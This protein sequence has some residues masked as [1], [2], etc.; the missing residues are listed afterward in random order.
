MDRKRMSA[1]AIMSTLIMAITVIFSS[2][3][4]ASLSK[5]DNKNFDAE[6]VLQLNPDNKL[7]FEEGGNW[8][9]P[10]ASNSPFI[11]TTNNGNN[12]TFRHSGGRSLTSTD[13]DFCI[14]RNNVGWIA[15]ESP[16]TG[17]TK[18]EIQCN[19]SLGIKF[20]FSYDEPLN[21]YSYSSE[22]VPL[23]VDYRTDEL[24]GSS[25]YT[26]IPDDMGYSYFRF[27]EIGSGNNWIKYINIYYS[28]ARPHVHEWEHIDEDPEYHE[29]NGVAEHE[30]C[31]ICGRMRDMD[32][33]F[34]TDADLLLEPVVYDLPCDNTAVALK[35]SVPV[36]STSILEFDFKIKDPNERFIVKLLQDWSNYI[37]YHGGIE[38]GTNTSG[39]LFAG[40]TVQQMVGGWTRLTIDM[41]QLNMAYRV[42]GT[43]TEIKSIYVDKNTG[44]TTGAYLEVNSKA[45]NFGRGHYYEGLVDY[46]YELKSSQYT[47]F[48][49]L[50]VNVDVYWEGKV[51]TADNNYLRVMIAE[52]WDDFYGYYKLYPT[53]ET[54]DY[55]GLTVS[56]CADGYTRYTFRINNCELINGG[57]PSTLKFIYIHKWSGAIAWV[58]YSWETHIHEWEKHDAVSPFREADGNIEYYT[59][60]DPE[61]H[62][63]KD[64]DSNLIT[65]DDVVDPSRLKRY[66]NGTDANFHFKNQIPKSEVMTIDFKA[67]DPTKKTCFGLMQDETWDNL[68]GYY[69]FFGDGTSEDSYAG[70]TTA[71]L[72]DGYIRITFDLSE[73]N[74]IN[75]TTPVENTL[76]GVKW[77]YVRGAWT[78]TGGYFDCNVKGSEVARGESFFNGE[79][80]TLDLD[81]TLQNTSVINIDLYFL[82]GT[83]VALSLYDHTYGNWNHYFGNY[84]L[85]SD[86]ADMDR[87]DGVTATL[88]DDGYIRYTFTISE[89]TRKSGSPR[90]VD[91]IAIRGA[92]TNADGYIDI[93]YVEDFDSPVREDIY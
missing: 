18:I 76:T 88:L 30:V 78:G 64:K 69:S 62:K 13:N 70:V 55:P 23:Y 4:L 89:L 60:K 83:T 7:T 50:L 39:Q 41:S 75:S 77:V 86:I 6:Y 11:R 8:D 82:E 5:A 48:D 52:N 61:C 81:H 84:N 54:G 43:V 63:I 45:N 85:R 53:T 16:I 9:N 37:G 65:T 3:N 56:Q 58:D 67:D 29:K 27:Q 10:K 42:S 49:D 38:F 26:V 12:I 71:H 2:T 68:Y 20:D 36:A 74:K 93:S 80:L 21:D 28:C 25:T 44:A 15:N 90:V 59:C 66:E 46:T 34:V 35:T 24:S 17:I 40:C 72:L 91:F 32:G 57:Q 47:D 79:G 19:A 31:S 22:N 14:A 87:Y 1:I 33:D 92:W 51:E 73:L